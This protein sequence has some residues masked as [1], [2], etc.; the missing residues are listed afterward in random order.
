MNRFHLTFPQHLIDEPLIYNL[1]REFDV[2]T[3][4][5]RA[6]VEE[7]V[8]WVIVEL[9]GSDDEIARAVEWL[10]DRGVEIDRIRDDL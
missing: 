5:R 3:N 6:N 2:V 8:A 9:T 7:N 10:A 1:G 4:I